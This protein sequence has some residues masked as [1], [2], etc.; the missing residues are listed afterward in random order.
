MN[1]KFEKALDELL[2]N[3]AGLGHST[4]DE[5]FDKLRALHRAALEDAER[6]RKVEAEPDLTPWLREYHSGVCLSVEAID[7]ARNAKP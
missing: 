4:I 7:A 2:N 1:D 6:W 3:F 5:C